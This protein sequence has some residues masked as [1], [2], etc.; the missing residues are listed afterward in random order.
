[1]NILNHE[2]PYTFLETCAAEN[3]AIETRLIPAEGI[4]VENRGPFKCRSGCPYYGTSLV[5]PPHALL[6]DEF[7]TVIRDYTWAF[8]VRFQTSVSVRD[9]IACSLL[10]TMADPDISSALKEETHNFFIGFGSDS[11]RFHHAMLRLEKSAF[12]AGYP[13]AVALMAGPCMLCD[14]CCGIR[15]SCAHPT[16]RRFPADALG[17]NIIKTANFAGMNV[18]FPF[19]ESPS[20][21][22][23]LLVD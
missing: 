17:V 3:G 21:I 20:S 15:G 22:G 7:R 4:I 11:K 10:Q 5:C 2:N 14:T 9:E 1:M 16:M 18:S 12:V 8:I 23:I 19:H 13:F 6:P